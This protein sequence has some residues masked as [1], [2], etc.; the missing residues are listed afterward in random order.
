MRTVKGIVSFQK[1]KKVLQHSPQKKKMQ[2]KQTCRGF[3]VC[4]DNSAEN[5]ELCD[6]RLITHLIYN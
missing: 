4:V 2:A 5:T 6:W 3:L 1:Q